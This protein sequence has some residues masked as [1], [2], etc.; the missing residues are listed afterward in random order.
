MAKVVVLEA[1]HFVGVGV[2]HEVSAVLPASV[3]AADKVTN[4]SLL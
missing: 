1:V 2:Y 3:Q 4:Q